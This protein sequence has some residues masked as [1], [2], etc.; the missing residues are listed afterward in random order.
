MNDIAK[1]KSVVKI[2]NMLELMGIWIILIMALG[3]Q[4]FLHDLPCPLCILQRIGFFGVALGLLMNLR[5]GPHPSHY[6]I[7]LLSALFTSLVALRQIALHVVP[8]TGSYGAPFLGIH[9]Y[10]WSFIISMIILI[11]TTLLLGIDRQYQNNYVVKMRSH[12]VTHLLLLITTILIITN[13]ILIFLQCG[14]SAC[15]DNPTS[16]KL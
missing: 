9:L 6:S 10:T 14:L 7:V 16:Y 4:I 11:V 1:I 13:L 8:G 15:P 3:F 5:L 2:F 12:W